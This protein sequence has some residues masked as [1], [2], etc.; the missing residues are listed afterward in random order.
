MTADGRATLSTLIDTLGYLNQ[1]TVISITP[2]NSPIQNGRNITQRRLDS[3]R[4]SLLQQQ[5]VT[6][7]F[8]PNKAQRSNSTRANEWRIRVRR[9]LK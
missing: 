3:L 6:V 2:I 7:K 4:A 1:G 8:L 5:R 9:E